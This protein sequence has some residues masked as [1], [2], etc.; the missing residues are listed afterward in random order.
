MSKKIA[1]NLTIKD[2][3]KIYTTVKKRKRKR[4]NKRLYKNI[5]QDN[6]TTDSSHMMGST[7]F[8]RNNQN[9]AN[10]NLRAQYKLI[11]DSINKDNL[12][13]DKIKDDFEKLTLA[14]AGVQ[15]QNNRFNTDLYDVQNAVTGVQT[16]NNRFNTDIYKI[17]NDFNTAKNRGFKSIQLLTNELNNIKNKYIND[18]SGS[19]GDSGG[20][21]EFK[22]REDR[23]LISHETNINNNNDNNNQTGLI[24]AIDTNTNPI[25]ENNRILSDKSNNMNTN[26]GVYETKE[27]DKPT[28][29]I[30]PKKRRVKTKEEIKDKHDELKQIQEEYSNL[31]KQI[32]KN[33]V[34]NINKR[35]IDAKDLKDI[36]YIKRAYKNFKKKYNI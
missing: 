2:L 13:K 10:E 8:N 32:H 5:Y 33:D 35:I 11:E 31:Y 12:N 6:I 16:Q 17:R 22:G 21:D 30:I 29:L 14:V 25:E 23:L 4:K 3:K 15:N 34:K 28:E 20:S 18:Q 7:V 19:F 36:I 9:L 27:D 24:E 26:Q 1:L